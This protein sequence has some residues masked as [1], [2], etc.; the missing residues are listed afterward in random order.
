MT[1][2]EKPITALS[3]STS[4]PVS[5]DLEILLNMLKPEERKNLIAFVKKG[6]NEDIS[7]EDLMKRYSVLLT[8]TKGFNI[9]FILAIASGFI[10]PAQTI[11]ENGRANFERIENE[12]DA[13]KS[14]Q[15]PAKVE[16]SV[17]MPKI[18]EN[19]TNF[20]NKKDISIAVTASSS[21]TSVPSKESKNPVVR[22]TAPQGG[23]V[24]S[25]PAVH[26]TAEQNE[27]NASA[28]DQTKNPKVSNPK[29]D[30]GNSRK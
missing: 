22:S 16:A 28:L 27:K 11:N 12:F 26:T 29:K 5:A 14:K 8:G 19:I 4:S 21:I 24:M 20:L 2:P 15:G 6:S 7:K 13:A 1:N 3:Q 18:I 10:T 30:P 25:G 9:H 23:S 17:D